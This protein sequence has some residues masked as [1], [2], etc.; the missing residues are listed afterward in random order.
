M[1]RILPRLVK[2]PLSGTYPFPNNKP[3]SPPR[4]PVPPL[5]SVLPQDYPRSVLLSPGNIITNS[6]DYVHHKTMAPLPTRRFRR[7]RVSQQTAFAED[8]RREMSA[9][10]RLWWSNPYLRMLA[11]PIRQCFL[12]KRYLPTDLMIRLAGMRVPEHMQ[13]TRKGTSRVIFP[14]GLQHPMFKQRKAGSGRYIMCCRAALSILDRPARFKGFAAAPR[15]R[16]G[17]HVAHLL[18]LRVLQELLLLARALEALYHTRTGPAPA[19]PPVLRRLTRAE[20]TQLRTTGILPQPGALAVLV[21]PPVNRDPKTKQRPP[22]ADAMSDRPL[23]DPSQPRPPPPPKRAAPPLSV[24]HPTRAPPPPPS[25]STHI[26]ASPS[27]FWAGV[28]RERAAAEAPAASFIQN[29]TPSKEAEVTEVRVPPHAEDRVPLY[30]GVA[31]FP[32]RVQRARLH[33]LLTRI[34]GVEGAWR[35]S[36]GSG[37]EGGNAGNRDGDAMRKGDNKGSH[38][39]LLCSS[40]EV[41][42]VAL[43]IALW[44]IR[45]WEGG[46]WRLDGEEEEEEGEHWPWVEEKRSQ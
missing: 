18:R 28:R 31:L 45:M 6:D 30:N 23:T 34:L 46:G 22:A 19:R 37:E 32:G 24:L 16:L 1:P 36:A 27:E 33:S 42:V 21:V 13:Q 29:L 43:G 15:P 3:P 17:E 7:R 35:F 26:E 8:G 11:S 9:Q 2:L 25:V 38:A 40:D 20:W 14:D 10:E 41:D 39:F 44:R 4:R 12:S 5:H